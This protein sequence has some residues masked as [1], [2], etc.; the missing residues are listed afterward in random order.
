MHT[1]CSLPDDLFSVYALSPESSLQM[2][3]LLQMAIANV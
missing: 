1:V 3:S 2:E